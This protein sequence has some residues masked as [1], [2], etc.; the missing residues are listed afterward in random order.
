MFKKFIAVIA[1][2][3]IVLCL[4]SCSKAVTDS[5]PLKES[6]FISSKVDEETSF[7][8]DEYEHYVIVTGISDSPDE[9]EIPEILGNKEVHAIAED[10]FSDMGWVKSIR[11]PDTVL[12]IGDNAFAGSISAEKITLSE[13]LYKIGT[14]AFSGCFS[15]ENIRLPLT[16]KIIG[17]FAFAECK[18]LE[19]IAVPGGVTSIGGGAFAGTKWLENQTDEFV[20]AGDNI[21]I[22]YNGEKEK[23]I[24]PDGIKEISAFYDNF[25]VNEI[26]FP[27]SAE[28]IGEYAFLNSSVTKVTLSKNVTSI[29][30]NAFDGCLNLK[31]INFNENIEAIGNYAF[32]AC[33]SLEEFTVPESVKN[34]GDGTFTRCENLKK[35]TFVSHETEIGEDICDSCSSLEKIACPENSPVVAYAKDAG[36]SLDITE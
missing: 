5:S 20:V 30:N 6:D 8:Y 32:S 4:F 21:L 26:I 28:R 3:S 11:I 36:F 19:G 34:I 17:G 13:N 29:G 9:I 15:I 27:E 31:E 7:Q 23:V 2:I 24:V 33:Q 25:F 1:V 22:H 35:L 14:S 16:L 18:K 10:A 12:E